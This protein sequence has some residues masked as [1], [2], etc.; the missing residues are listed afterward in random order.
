MFNKNNLVWLKGNAICKQ[1]KLLCFYVLM[2]T[3]KLT[4]GIRTWHSAIALIISA[5]QGKLFI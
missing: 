1:N 5:L 3:L 4:F 2:V